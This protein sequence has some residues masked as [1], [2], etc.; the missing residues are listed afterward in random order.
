M[1]AHMNNL[2]FSIFHCIISLMHFWI[3]IPN[4]KT[5]EL[6]FKNLHLTF[7][8]TNLVLLIYFLHRCG[9]KIRCRC[10][11]AAPE[12]R[13]R[14]SNIIDRRVISKMMGHVP[15]DLIQNQDFGRRKIGMLKRKS[16][17]RGFR[18][19]WFQIF[20]S[21]IEIQK[22]LEKTIFKFLKSNFRV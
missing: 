15:V 7:C 11:G 4:L 14:V 18:R 8:T 9:R 6:F 2:K 17:F 21:Q 10:A 12:R 19:W 20:R 13:D 3:Q 5:D 22:E 16:R 1:I